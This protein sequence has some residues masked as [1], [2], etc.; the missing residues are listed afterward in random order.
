MQMV[1]LIGGL[2]G[3]KVNKVVKVVVVTVAM[4]M[5][6]KKNIQ[7]FFAKKNEEREERN[8]EGV[9]TG[10]RQISRILKVTMARPVCPKGLGL[11][12]HYARETSRKMNK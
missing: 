8:A 1:V 11:V 7:K 10:E 6:I 9:V 12:F 2:V 5:A 3:A 4:V